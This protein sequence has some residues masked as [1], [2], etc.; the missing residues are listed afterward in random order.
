MLRTRDGKAAADAGLV[1]TAVGIDNSV[2]HDGVEWC[3][4]V[5]AASAEHAA[6]ELARYRSEN[7]PPPPRQ[8]FVPV[9][10]GWF[11]VFG[12]LFAIWLLPLCEATL[13]LGW[14]W[15]D[16]GTMRAE[17]VRDGEWWRTVTA[18]TLHA[19]LGHIL[20][21]SAFGT[22]FG[23]FAGRL[24]GSG[25][26]W[27]L[28][29]LAGASGNAIDAA[30]Q[31]D[32]FASIGASTAVFAGLG[33]IGAFVWRRRTFRGIGFR[34]AAA[35]MFAAF[36]LLAYT[37]VGDEQV[38]V[39]AHFAGFICGAVVGIV[40]ALVRLDRVSPA[41]QGI[42]G[43]LALVVVAAAWTLAGTAPG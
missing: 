36:A 16:I 14:D 31:G 15:R 4:F 19:D 20:A 24:L 27:L 32:G 39:V 21:N 6:A 30:V 1:L 7:V 23:L 8:S 35:P 12:Y 5:L 13:A 9:D 41:T 40:A 2:E 29:V 18:L 43:A 28:I 37:G 3:V 11:G 26:A 22:V 33:M 34:R 38:D 10:S 42:S 25:V 17:A